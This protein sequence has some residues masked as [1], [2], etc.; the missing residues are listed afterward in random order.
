MALGLGRWR[1]LSG[2]CAIRAKISNRWSYR[3]GQKGHCRQRAPSV[4]KNPEGRGSGLLLEMQETTKVL[5]LFFKSLLRYIYSFIYLFLAVLGLR[6]CA[7]DF[8]C[9]EQALEHRLSSFGT[10]ASSLHSMWDLPGPGIEPMSTE[11]AGRFL[12][13]R[14]PG[15]SSFLE[16]FLFYVG[17]S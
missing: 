2:G 17:V 5:F 6:C 7:Q 14:P 3:R 10:Q 8:S 12:T 4:P 9:G 15:K 16:N 1:W 11:L 13:A